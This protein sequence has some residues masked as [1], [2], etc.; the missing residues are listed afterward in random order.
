MGDLL[1]GEIKQGCICNTNAKSAIKTER[2]SHAE[3]KSVKLSL[4]CVS[5]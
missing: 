4:F 2:E 3:V 1:I 5:V